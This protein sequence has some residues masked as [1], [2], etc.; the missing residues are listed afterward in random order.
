MAVHDIKRGVSLYSFQEEVFLRKLTLDDAVRVCAEMGARGIEV[1]PE[2]S[3]DSFPNLTDAE[4]AG[5]HELHAKYGTTPTA[6]DMFID[7]KR[8]KDRVMTFEEGVESIVRDIKLANKLGCTSMR[9]IV[10][11]PPEVFEAAAPYAE[12]YDVRLGVEIHAPMRFDHRWIQQFLDIVHRVDSHYLGIVPD[13]GIFVR[14]FPR[15]VA[16]RFKRDGARPDLVD[17]AVKVYNDHP[18]DMETLTRELAWRGGT[19]IDVAF[20]NNVVGYNYVAPETMAPHV[21]YI[22]HIHAKFYEMVGD[23]REYSIPYDEIVPVLIAGGYDGYLSS[24]YE[25]NRHI[26]DVRPVDSVQEVAHQQ[27][28][29]ARLLGEETTTGGSR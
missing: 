3:F 6:Y 15:V 14:E 9:V 2:Q 22:V 24:E 23:E 11:T 28:M 27:R 17:H 18:D 1:I 25:G 20:A 12:E 8:R 29:L 5:W 13:M 10:N 19:A 7:L 16:E 26:Q 21:P 4:I